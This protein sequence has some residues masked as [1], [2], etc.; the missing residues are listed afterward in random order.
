MRSP[1]PATAL[2]PS[3]AS[4]TTPAFEYPGYAGYFGKTPVPGFVHC[5][6]EKKAN[7][8]PMLINERRVSTGEL[9]TLRRQHR[10]LLPATSCGPGKTSRRLLLVLST[11]DISAIHR[12]AL[13]GSRS[14][15]DFSRGYSS[16][17]ADTASKCIG[18]SPTWT[19]RSIPPPFKLT[20]M[21]AF[22]LQIVCGRDSESGKRVTVSVSLITFTTAQT[23]AEIVRLI[24]DRRRKLVDGAHR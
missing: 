20:P 8:V 12:V 16:C 18:Q 23:P 21:S 2:F 15:L 3:P 19:E 4:T 10:V 22:V 9:A 5:R 1:G 7:S 11:S 6:P 14:N 17:F 24:A 13:R